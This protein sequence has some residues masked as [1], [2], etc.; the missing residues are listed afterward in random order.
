MKSC[1]KK[2]VLALD[3]GGTHF[4]FSAMS[5][6]RRLG[7][8]VSFG[9][10][11]DDLRKSIDTLFEGF[12]VVV[13][14]FGAEAVDAVSVAFPGPCDYVEGIVFEQ[15]NLPAYRGG[16][17]LK[18][19]LEKEF[20]IPVFMNNDADLFA[21]G[22]AH[23][24]LLQRVNN[25]L[26]ANGSSRLYRNLLGVTL[27]TGFGAGIVS[28]G[29]LFRGDNSSAGEVWALR[30][31]K[32]PHC[33][34]EAAVGAKGLV[35]S[36]KRFAGIADSIALSPKNIADIARGA[37]AGN[38]EAARLAFW[39]FGE[40]L[41]DALAGISTIVD[42]LIV[43]GGGLS[44]SYDLFIEP[45]LKELRAKTKSLDGNEISKLT[46]DIYDL[47][48]QEEYEAFCRKKEVS[49]LVPFSNEEIAY[50]GTR[51]IGIGKAC[52]ETSLSVAIGACLVAQKN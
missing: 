4:V 6:Y 27:G 17:P 12:Y 35:E 11:G 45:V 50:D 30:N 16:I 36:Y 5:G 23:R 7:N 32:F 26:S 8:S 18:R 13:K 14:E 31:K 22:E 52:N 38:C 44:N 21:L 47:E 46:Y 9:S 33:Y 24:G 2:N 10:F 37:G 25:S 3:A 19:M 41:G 48:K 39:E 43:I 40:V 29:R 51:K 1:Q 49:I 20:G 28:E 34:V 42:G 15:K